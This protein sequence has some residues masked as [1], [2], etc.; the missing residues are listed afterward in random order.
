MRAS[1]GLVLARADEKTVSDGVSRAGTFGA[2]DGT[3]D[4]VIGEE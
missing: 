3:C 2:D 4:Q 1:G